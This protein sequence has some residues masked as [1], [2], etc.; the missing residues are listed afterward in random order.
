[1]K[2]FTD[3]YD[4]LAEARATDIGISEEVL[5]HGIS[6][7]AVLGVSFMNDATNSSIWKRKQLTNLVARITLLINKE[8]LAKRDFTNAFLSRRSM[9]LDAVLRVLRNCQSVSIDPFDKHPF[10]LDDV[11][12]LILMQVRLTSCAWQDGSGQPTN[13][14]EAAESNGSAHFHRHV[15]RYAPPALN[16]AFRYVFVGLHFLIA[17][18]RRLSCL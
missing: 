17:S 2:L 15:L 16:M 7:V 4:G 11:S 12:L 9:K 13:N 10:I 3:G 18:P 1:V 14:S 6:G 8:A 5:A